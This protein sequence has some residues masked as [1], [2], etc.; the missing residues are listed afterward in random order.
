MV[1]SSSDQ[2]NHFSTP[3]A[4]AVN[5]QS[6]AIPSRQRNYA[7]FHPKALPKDIDL[8]SRLICD[9]NQGLA[10]LSRCLSAAS[11]SLWSKSMPTACACASSYPGGGSSGAVKFGGEVS[12]GVCNASAAPLFLTCGRVGTGLSILGPSSSLSTSRAGS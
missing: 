8:R 12:V 1:Y 3:C 11:R 6:C 9:A 5:E 7:F 4:D 10:S 2:Y